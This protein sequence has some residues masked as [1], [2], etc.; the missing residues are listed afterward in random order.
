M[1]FVS[2]Y[3]V[4]ASKNFQRLFTSVCSIQRHLSW[5]VNHI[6]LCLVAWW[7]KEVL[8][9]YILAIR[10]HLDQV[11]YGANAWQT[12]DQRNIVL[13]STVPFL[14]FC[15]RIQSLTFFWFWASKNL[16][17]LSLGKMEKASV[18]EVR[19]HKNFVFTDREWAS[20]ATFKLFNFSYNNLS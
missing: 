17:L 18:L 11:S 3:V 14:Y 6:R 12:I 2:K 4:A 20:L 15:V 13:K 10:G 9:K 5:G 16:F 7:D 19:S 8:A 1:F